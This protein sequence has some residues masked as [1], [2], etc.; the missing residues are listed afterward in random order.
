MTN[1]KDLKVQMNMAIL[2]KRAK[3]LYNIHNNNNH[4]CTL[5]QES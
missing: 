4:K 3:T 2:K 5:M 1:E